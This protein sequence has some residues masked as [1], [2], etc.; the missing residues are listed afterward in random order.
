M[1]APSNRR[2]RGGGGHAEHDSSER[3]LLTYA[4]MITLLL[5]LFIVL[6]SISSVNVSKFAALKQSLT[7]AFSGKVLQGS[8]GILSGGTAPL[9]PEGTQVQNIN[10]S[11]SSSSATFPN[12][13]SISDSIRSEINSALAQSEIDNLKRVQAEIRAKAQEL[14]LS[15][16]IHTS[17]QERGLV[18]RLLTDKVLFAS[19]QAV[20]EPRSIPLLTAIGKILAHDGMTNPVRVE[21]NTD[22]VPISTAQ[23]PSNWELSAARASAVLEDLVHGG[24][25]QLRL[26]VTGYGKE[27][28]VASNLTV[29]GRALNRRVDIV[30][31]RKSSTQVGASK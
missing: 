22:N 5:A 7:E 29:R 27:N 6:W 3:W 12:P 20:V 17:I 26:S 8:S 31:L 16:T 24:V 15:G 1:S 2:R 13:N 30:V 18:I 25:P 14:G 10:A 23:F 9:E 19:G 28:P 4:D 21:G 11:S